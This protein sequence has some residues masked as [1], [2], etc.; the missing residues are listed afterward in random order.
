MTP[1]FVIAVFAIFAA[2]AWLHMRNLGLPFDLDSYDEGVYWQSLRAMSA[3][4]LL[5]RDIFYSQPP[6][7]LFSF[8]PTY[9][10]AG[11]TLWAARLGALVIS[12]CGLLGAFLLGRALTGR[13]GA[14]AAL[15]L[16]AVN[17]QYFEFSMKIQA[18]GAVASLMLLAVA[19]AYLWWEQPAGLAGICLASL[20]GGVLALALLTKLFALAALV[21]VG[22]LA[23]AHLWRVL[24][25]KPAQLFARSGSLL[26][27][28]ATF[29]VA[30]M[31]VLLPFAGAAGE[32]LRDVVTFHLAADP[33]GSHGL[34][35]ILAGNLANNRPAIT[36]IL[37]TFMPLAA[38]CGTVVALLRRD[39]RVL[40]LLAWLVATVVLLARQNPLFPHHFVILAPPLVAL[41]VVGI[42]RIEL[43]RARRS[44]VLFSTVM[45][46]VV[47]LAVSSWNLWETRAYLRSLNGQNQSPETQ[48]NLRVANDLRQALAAGEYVITDA[49]FIAGLADRSTPPELVDTSAVRIDAGYLNSAQLIRAASQPQVRAVLFYS[50]RFNKPQL[51]AFHTWVAQHYRL[52]HDYGGGRTLWSKIE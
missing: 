20:S 43:A 36:S 30:G 49:Q 48:Q 8:F 42:G 37:N 1:L 50:G 52:L 44:A 18:D 41:T 19:L 33:A 9:L 16:L 21:P 15:L 25:Q 3:G 35:D 17:S 38:L 13:V 29:V 47:I 11:Q 24:R 34:A 4:H 14:L 5:Y 46:V 31:A 32:L 28:V 7:F 12:L 40:S 39:W 22:L 45:M 6:F 2:N 27:G 10:L 26:A 51:A 23:L